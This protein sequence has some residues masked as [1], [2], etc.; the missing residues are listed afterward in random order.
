MNA[1]NQHVEGD[2]R[3]RPPSAC[4]RSRWWP[5]TSGRSPSPG[6]RSPAGSPWQRVII[7]RNESSTDGER[8][9]EGALGDRAGQLRGTGAARLKARTTSTS[10]TSMVVGMLTSGSTS[11]VTSRRRIRRVQDP[12]QQRRTLSAS[13]M[14]RRDTRGGAGRVANADERGGG[15]EDQRPASANRSISD[16]DAPLRRHGE[17][18]EQQDR[19]AEVDD[20]AGEDARHG[21]SAPA[22]GGRASR[23]RRGGTRVARNSGTRKMRILALIV[24]SSCQDDAADARASRTSTRQARSIAER[25][26]R[27]GDA[28]GKEDR[29]PDARSRRSSLSAGRPLDE[30]EV[31]ARILEDHGLVDH[32]ELEVRRRDCRPARARSPPASTIVKATP[33]KAR[34]G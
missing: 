31:A 21:A 20:L 6:S 17:R 33:A 10:P 16:Q 25:V 13:V 2:G 29:D 28:P 22:A 34:L 27:R 15:G 23:A 18:D 24:S 14:T 12:R 5:R 1:A 26:V 30:R 7:I 9:A 19:R 3:S 4:R 32:G 8:D 11:H